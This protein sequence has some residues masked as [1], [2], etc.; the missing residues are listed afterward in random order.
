MSPTATRM[1]DAR[2]ICG[3]LGGHW[4]GQYGVAAMLATFF[5]LRAIR[6]NAEHAEARR[7]VP[8]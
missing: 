5:E 4:H 2:T 8:L 6:Q 1:A 3:A 7:R